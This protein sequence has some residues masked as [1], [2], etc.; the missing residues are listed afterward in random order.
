MSGGWLAALLLIGFALPGADL[1]AESAEL[2]ALPY[3]EAQFKAA[4][5]SIDQ[6]ESLAEQLEW[7]EAE[8]ARGGCRGI[9]LDLVLDPDSLKPGQSWVFGVQHGG[10]FRLDTPRLLDCLRQ[11]RSW[12][13]AHPRH[14]VITVHLD[15]KREATLGEDGAFVKE[16]DG[17]LA[18]ELGK[19]RI[20]T[21]GALQRGEA[22]LLAGARKRGWPRLGELRGKL[23]LV[24]SGEDR[25]EPVARRRRA[26]ASAAP[27]ERLCFVDLDQRAGGVEGFDECDLQSPYY[28]GGSRVFLNLQLGRK[29]WTGLA[30]RAHAQGFVTREWRANTEES[31]RTS[32]D[33]GINVLST[34]RIQGEAWASVGPSTFARIGG[35]K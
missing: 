20:F 30:R 8:P 21:P 9:E 10:A 14:S 5:N 1:P 26:Y 16:I 22:T 7:K 24:F 4:H 18:R 25:D 29:D 35:G 33:A 6:K 2:D 12:I 3:N 13:E 28:Q 32:R 31:W 27:G 34:D 23:I 19:E 11:V 15:L 17:L